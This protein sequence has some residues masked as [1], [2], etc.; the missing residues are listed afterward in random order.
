[1]SEQQAKAAIILA[2]QRLTFWQF[3]TASLF[4]YIVAVVAMY[5]GG[6]LGAL[7]TEM[8]AAATTVLLLYGLLLFSLQRPG[9]AVVVV[10]LLA[11]I[12][13]C[14]L[15]AHIPAGLFWLFWSKPGLHWME[16]HGF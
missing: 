6:P 5:L 12:H 2:G 10:V 11:A 7:A 13:I 14:L 4:A 1:M 8:I 3:L 9:T 16:D 15:R